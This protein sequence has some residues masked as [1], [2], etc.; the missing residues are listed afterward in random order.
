MGRF[1]S[2]YEA[3]C[4]AEV[5][6]D[7]LEDFSREQPHCHNCGSYDLYTVWSNP[8]KVTHEARILSRKCADCGQ[9]IRK[10]RAEE[11]RG[12]TWLGDEWR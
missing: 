11:L 10:E 3:A 1:D 6:V 4:D 2:L 7:E 8:K 5:A 12:K 9:K